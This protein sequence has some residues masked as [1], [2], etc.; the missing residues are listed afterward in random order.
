M[1]R[2]IP[3]KATNE[4]FERGYYGHGRGVVVTQDEPGVFNERPMTAGELAARAPAWAIGADP[5]EFLTRAALFAYIR[6]WEVVAPGIDAALAAQADSHETR[7]GELLAANNR[8][9]E[10]RRAA[11]AER[12]AALAELAELRNVLSRDD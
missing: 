4:D 11:E 2:A 9:V 1:S 7:V 10:R 3:M 8:E 5:Y 12:D 6:V